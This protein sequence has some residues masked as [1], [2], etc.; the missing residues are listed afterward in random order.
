MKPAV[1]A[2]C[3]I[4]LSCLAAQA[5]TQSKNR[6]RITGLVMDEA[7]HPIVDA[8]LGIAETT[9]QGEL[10]EMAPMTNEKGEFEFTDLPPGRYTLLVNAP[11]YQARKHVVEVKAGE[12]TKT[13]VALKK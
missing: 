4:T 5:L 13:E 9:A 6:G 7:K 3:L 1:L 12:T 11:G 8:I 2:V 10:N